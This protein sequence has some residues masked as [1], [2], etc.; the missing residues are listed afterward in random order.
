MNDHPFYGQKVRVKQAIL[1]SKFKESLERA[2]NNRNQ[3]IYLGRRQAKYQSA[4][5]LEAGEKSEDRKQGSRSREE[6]ESMLSSQKLRNHWLAPK[7][8]QDQTRIGGFKESQQSL[9]PLATRTAFNPSQGQGFET[10]SALSSHFHSGARQQ[11]RKLRL[12][13]LDQQQPK[14]PF[15]AEEQQ[16]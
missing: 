4:A 9:L 10:R 3:V 16:S 7:S 11:L 5:V 8:R 14:T 13:R 6:R 1:D 2:S 12:A 15:T